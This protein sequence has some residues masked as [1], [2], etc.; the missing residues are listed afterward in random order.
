VEKPI[1][2]SYPPSRVTD[3]KIL[4]MQVDQMSVTIEWTATGQQMDQGI[5]NALF[6]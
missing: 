5:G 2:T 3:L 6:F 1:V 4:S